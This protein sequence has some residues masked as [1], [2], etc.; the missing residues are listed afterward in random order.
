MPSRTRSRGAC[1]ARSRSSTAARP[2]RPRRAPRCRSS[3]CRAA[4]AGGNAFFIQELLD[5]LIERG[6]VVPDGDDGEYPG[7]LR[8]VKRDAPIHVP[9][10]VED[11]IITRVDSLP[12]AEREALIHASVLGR[13]VSAAQLAQLLGRPVRLEL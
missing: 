11:L 9:S 8:W 10:S 7:L 3:A 2:T 5:M 12:T 13:H 1:C 6:I 4:R